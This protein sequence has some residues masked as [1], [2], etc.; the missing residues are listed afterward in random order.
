MEVHHHPD[1][2]HKPKPWK[3]YLLEYFMIFLAVM[4]GFFAESIRE[5]IS[6][7]A[8]G[9]EYI[10]SFVEDLRSD[11]AQYDA[12]IK[13][14][15]IKDSVLNQLYACLDTIKQ[16]HHTPIY[17]RA[18]IAESSG[19][20]DFI[21]TDRTIQQLKN[22]GGLRMIHDKA[23]AD[24]IISYDALVRAELIHQGAMEEWQQIATEAHLNMVSAQHFKN[25]GMNA[26]SNHQAGQIV[27]LSNDPRE[28]DS[29]FNKMWMF[30]STC[31]GQK[32]RLQRLRAK[33]VR[34][35]TFLEK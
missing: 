12:S 30:K 6:D 31:L 25:I 13:E 24:S 21:Y 15:T 16:K 9:K 32:E 34:I 33:A 18:I 27:L 10:R 26:G 17:M 28:L 2:H 4:T 11:T 3:E 22:S 19:F 5:N 29:Y 1:L 20:T 14:L 7:N 35:I 23:A 8:K